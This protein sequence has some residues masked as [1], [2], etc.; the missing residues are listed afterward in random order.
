M[1]TISNI[2]TAY[3]SSSASNTDELSFNEKLLNYIKENKPDGDLNNLMEQAKELSAEKNM[4]MTQFNSALIYAD[5]ILRA[6]P[7]YQSYTSETLDKRTIQMLSINMLR[8]KMLDK[9]T[10]TDEDQEFL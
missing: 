5:T 9:L 10:S 4:T 7:D 3:Q 2:D 8:N 6:N 1:T